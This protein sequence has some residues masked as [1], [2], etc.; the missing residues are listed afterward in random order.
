[1]MA[2]KRAMEP[3]IRLANLV[4]S[5]LFVAFV[6]GLN[7]LMGVGLSERACLTI[8]EMVLTRHTIL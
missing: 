3:L 4:G 6:Q 5:S 8:V 2:E 1:M 7:M